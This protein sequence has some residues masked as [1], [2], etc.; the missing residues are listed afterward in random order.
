MNG[1]SQV[2][3]FAYARRASHHLRQTPFVL[4][5]TGLSASGKSTLA[6]HI[7]SLLRAHGRHT[8]ILDGDTVRSGLCRDLGFDTDARNENIRR[9][10]E[11]A[12]L[13]ADSGLIVLVAAISPTA[14]CRHHA[15]SIIGNSRFVEVH[16]DASLEVVQARDPKGLYAKARRGL[17]KEFTGIDSVYQVPVSPEIRVCTGVLTIEQAGEQVMGWLTANLCDQLLAASAR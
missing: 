15:R 11:V 8:F 7:D 17:I 14:S 10:A 9:V 1:L 2:Y 6:N 12:A 3:P 5:F 13:M 16:V 4:W